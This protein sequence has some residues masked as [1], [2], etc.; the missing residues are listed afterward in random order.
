MRHGAPSATAILIAI[1]FT[2]LD[3][4]DGGVFARRSLLRR[5]LLAPIT[6]ATH[7]AFLTEPFQ[8]MATRLPPHLAAIIGFLKVGP[9]GFSRRPT[10]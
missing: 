9:R 4:L 7:G 10:D 5:S 8:G 1:T 6:G 2:P 3:P